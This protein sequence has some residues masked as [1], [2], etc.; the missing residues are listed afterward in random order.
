[1]S[2][3]TL[4]QIVTENFQLSQFILLNLFSY[5]YITLM[6]DQCKVSATLVIV[7]ISESLIISLKCLRYPLSR[8]TTPITSVVKIRRQ[9]RY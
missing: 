7:D 5:K 2:S 8:N 6:T 3:V 4:S 9:I 1:M